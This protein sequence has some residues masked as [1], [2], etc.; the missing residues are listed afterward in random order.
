MLHACKRRATSPCCCR[1]ATSWASCSGK[2]EPRCNVGSSAPA[3]VAAPA[4][5]SS[6]CSACTAKLTGDYKTAAGR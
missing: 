6:Q 1:P 3:R 5:W 2:L 4:R